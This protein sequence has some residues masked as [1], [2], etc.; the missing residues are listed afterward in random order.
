MKKPIKDIFK[1]NDYKP[2]IKISGPGVV[3]VKS[4]EIVKTPA[5]KRQIEILG[6]LKRK[7]LLD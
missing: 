3:H 6:K 5:A 2:K 7:G 4:S 1:S